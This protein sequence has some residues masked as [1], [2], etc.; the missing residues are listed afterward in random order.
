[1][2]GSQAGP[3]PPP[4]VRTDAPGR[5]GSPDRRDLLARLIRELDRSQWLTPA[6]TARRQGLLLRSLVRH[7]EAHSP[8]FRGRLRAA[9]L[10]VADLPDVDAL[11]RLPPL[12]RRAVQAAGG[13]LYCAQVPQ[14]HM[15]LQE[16]R[17]S[18]STGEPVVVRTTALKQL[19]WQGTTM[20]DHAWHRRDFSGR[21]SSVRPT[22]AAYG[23]HDDWGPPVSLLHATGRSQAIPVTTDIQE[24]LRLLEAFGPDMLIVFPNILAGL[25]EACRRR[26]RALVGLSRIRTIGETL[27]PAARAAATEAL[28]AAV[29]DLYSSHEFG[30]IAL[31]CPHGG[32]Y[33]VMAEYLHLEILDDRDRPCAP[34]E[35][36]RVVV[37][38]LMNLATPLLR[39]EIGDYAEAAA[40]CP[41]GRGLPTLRRIVGRERNLIRLPDGRRH[42]P[43]VGFARF[44]EVAP[45]VQY[46]L[47]Q[48][49][50]EEIEVRLVCERPPTAAEEEALGAVIRDALAYDFRLRYAYFPDRI[51]P[52]KNGKFEEFICRLG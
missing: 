5:R 50:P 12:T 26:G 49:A 33:H 34:G 39:Y 44:R 11:D 13:D 28:G 42:Y 9:G 17:T 47:I 22:H 2:S 35:I 8:Q 4:E 41:C 29:E 16:L 36:G 19:L 18:G 51:P 45:V 27:T 21:L 20:R 32:A 7:A 37:S 1:M 48:E 40:P 46:Q 43:L 52:S 38:D 6:E 31:E 24:M 30:N 14:A 23:E 25:V 15:P 3:S 10:R